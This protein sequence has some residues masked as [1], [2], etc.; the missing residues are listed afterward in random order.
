MD[1]VWRPVR[2]FDGIYE[3]SSHGRVK[4][5]ERFIMNNNV[6]Q[7][8]RERILK[9]NQHGNR[10]CT[11]VLCKDG[12][13]YSELIHRLV[14]DAFIPNPEN[15]PVVDHIDTNPLNNHVDNL[16]WATIQEN[17]LNPLTRKHNSSSKM[18]HPYRGR[19]LT[20]EEKAKISVA[21]SGRKLSDAHK[22][23]LSIS[24]KNSQKAIRATAC[25]IA[26]A[27]QANTGRHRTDETKEKIRERLIGAH[28]GK[29]WKVVDGK[30]VWYEKEN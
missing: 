20:E 8:K 27:H 18:G 2:G 1:E 14:A 15:K 26:K 16:R 11:V 3:V 23:A 13:T 4:S 17:C 24:H 7:R 30:R 9:P 12:S 5:L 28:K 29:G 6:I 19:P 25:N 10:R 21:L 22:E